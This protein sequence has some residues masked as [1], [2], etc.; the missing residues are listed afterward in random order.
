MTWKQRPMIKKSQRLL[1]LKHYRC[2]KRAIN[3]ATKY[4]VEVCVAQK[5]ASQFPLVRL[6]EDLIKTR[7][8]E[9]PGS[10]K[11]PFGAAAQLLELHDERNN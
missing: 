2:R 6:A 11:L 9:I 8:D 4:T 10:R 3:D 5:S 7:A 1:I